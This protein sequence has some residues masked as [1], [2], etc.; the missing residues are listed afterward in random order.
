M[1]MKDRDQKAKALRYCVAKRW[2]PQLEVDVRPGRHVGKKAALV[3][4]L[5]VLA[6]IP[7]EFLGFRG[8]VFDCKTR[9]RESAVNRSMWLRGILD[10]MQA[11]LGVCI[12]KKSAIE[13]DHKLAATELDIVLLAEDE[14]D[15]YANATCSQFDS[16]V[17]AIG[18]IDTWDAFFAIQSEI[19]NALFLLSLFCVRSFG[20]RRM[21]PVRVAG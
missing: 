9:A 17:G 12:L 15:I 11:D 5:D 1:S 7:D 3:T 16:P 21:S 13:S 19:P 4:D 10:L 8:V 14:F 6:F 20:C 18:E 2:F